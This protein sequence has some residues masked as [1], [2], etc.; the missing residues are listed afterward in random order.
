MKKHIC[1]ILDGTVMI[2]QYCVKISIYAVGAILAV[3][4][5]IAAMVAAALL[6][7]ILGLSSLDSEGDRMK[8]WIRKMRS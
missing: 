4:S 3:Y 5:T 8:G 2:L 7:L 6:G 1:D